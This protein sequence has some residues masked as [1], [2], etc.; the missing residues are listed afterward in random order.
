MLR[1]VAF[2][3]GNVKKSKGAIVLNGVNNKLI[4]LE[5]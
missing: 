3:F 5:E 2:D 1:K 4:I